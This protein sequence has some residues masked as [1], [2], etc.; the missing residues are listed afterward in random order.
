[1]CTSNGCDA[2]RAP[3]DRVIQRAQ[4]ALELSRGTRETR[5]RLALF[6]DEARDDVN[7]RMRALQVFDPGRF[8][9][10][11]SSLGGH[12][13][14]IYPVCLSGTSKMC[15]RMELSLE[16]YATLMAELIAAGDAREE[17]LARHGLDE[18]RWDAADTFWQERL[19][20]AL[21]DQEEEE[22]SGL[23]AKYSAAYEVAQRALLAPIALE[24]FARVT[25]L[26]Q[27]SG[28]LQ[29]SLAKAGISFAEYVR[30]SEHWSRR[31][32][33]DP[34]EERRFEAV[35]RSDEETPFSS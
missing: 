7:Q 16:A 26:L 5:V 21:D 24:K 4:A 27:A 20:D 19:N 29:S 32:A 15:A 10:E 12:R 3:I 33:E 34:E 22:G 9:V 13:H 30:S 1:M 8:R 31:M 35:L 23:L 6:L 18:E 25:R 14:I 11:S 17:V 28:D 2:L